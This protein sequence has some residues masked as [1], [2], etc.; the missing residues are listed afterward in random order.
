MKICY[1]I[2]KSILINKWG[3]ESEESWNI[4]YL[5]SL[6]E[7]FIPNF[8]YPYFEKDIDYSNKNYII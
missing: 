1:N 4:D 8:I 6:K 5:S 2:S 3:K 7:S